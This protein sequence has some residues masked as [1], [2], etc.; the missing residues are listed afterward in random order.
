MRFRGKPVPLAPKQT[1]V[2][3][4]RSTYFVGHDTGSLAH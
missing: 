3:I 1:I 2:V 4:V